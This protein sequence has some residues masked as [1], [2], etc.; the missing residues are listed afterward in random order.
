MTTAVYEMMMLWNCFLLFSLLTSQSEHIPSPHTQM[1]IFSSRGAFLL[2]RLMVVV[3]VV[4]VVV[5]TLRLWPLKN[6]TET[7]QGDR[8]L[9]N[10]AGCKHVGT[11]SS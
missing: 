7:L 9:W 3:V 6:Y 1:Q 4:V 5:T 10:V 11:N 8:R 2:A